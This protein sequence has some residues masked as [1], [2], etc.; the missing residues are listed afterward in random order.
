MELLG[1][2]VNVIL[3]IGNL[4]GRIFP[5]L[6]LISD[7]MKN[8]ATE[9]WQKRDVMEKIL[10]VWLE[11]PSLRLSQLI[12][13]AMGADDLPTLHLINDIMK[14]RATEEWQKRD[15]MEKILAVWLENP[16]LRL[17]QLIVNAMGADDPD[18]YSTEDY[19]L[20]DSVY[21]FSERYNKKI[22]IE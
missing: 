22:P 8:R 7:I 12:V 20:V 18:I 4:L 2:M 21:A 19:D 14:N 1:W 17:G 10:A 15:V 3:L 5:T 11:N 16:S 13:N 9:E 6:H